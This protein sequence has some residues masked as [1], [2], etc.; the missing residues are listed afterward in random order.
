MLKTFPSS[1]DLCSEN[2]VVR[3]WH[4]LVNLHIF[5][6]PFYLPMTQCQCFLAIGRDG[7]L[8][9]LRHSCGFACQ[10]RVLKMFPGPGDLR[11]EDGVVS[12]WHV[13]VNLHIFSSLF[14]LAMVQSQCFLS[15]V[16]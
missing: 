12:L 9:A 1:G 3:L 13:F 16:V 8:T 7:G 15:M 2:G 11:S 10:Q 14:Y 5:S 4:F 6:S